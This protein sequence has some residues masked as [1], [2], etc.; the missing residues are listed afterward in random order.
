MFTVTPYCASIAHDGQTVVPRGKLRRLES[1]SLQ[2][3]VRIGTP[4][5]VMSIGNSH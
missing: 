3:Q 2:E 1:I 5:A 4:F